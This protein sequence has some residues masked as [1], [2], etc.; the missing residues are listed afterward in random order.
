MFPSSFWLTTRTLGLGTLIGFKLGSQS[1][2]ISNTCSRPPSVRKCSFE[3]NL[4]RK[5]RVSMTVFSTGGT[6]RGGIVRRL[7]LTKPVGTATVMTRTEDPTAGLDIEAAIRIEVVAAVVGE[8]VAVITIEVEEEAVLVEAQVATTEEEEVGKE[9]P[10]NLS[11]T[12]ALVGVAIMHREESLITT[13][14]FRV[15]T[16]TIRHFLP[17]AAEVYLMASKFFVRC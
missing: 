4:R 14:M 3:S 12:W 11:M 2:Q 13:I 5:V 10:I 7:D 17:W 15:G 6:S 9:E 16:A 1:V 8:A